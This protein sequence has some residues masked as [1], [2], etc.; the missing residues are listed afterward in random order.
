MRAILFDFDGVL[1]KSMEDHYEGWRR[2]LLEYGIDMIPEELFI[3]EGQDLTAV[4]NQLTRKYNLP[5]E[6]TPVLIEKKQ[7]YYNSVKKVTFYPNLLDVLNW[8]RDKELKMAV[9]SGSNREWIIAALD[10]FG[11]SDY[12]DAIVTWEDVEYSKPS[13][14]P[15]LKA[16]ELLECEPE[17][18]V[19][20]EN[21]P[22]G[23]TSG[24]TAK[25]KVVAL[26]TT[27]S[28]FYL[29]EADVVVNNMIEL[30]AV[31]KK[32]Y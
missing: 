3:I 30:Q 27:L 26:T 23:I 4:A 9:V 14:Q 6:E 28:P 12:F 8:A 7:E 16:A 22:L 25:M 31:L 21:A 2:A 19:V 15:Y 11:L 18:C 17:Q 32:I 29:R 24:K 5:L 1:V 13:P 20:I 10:E